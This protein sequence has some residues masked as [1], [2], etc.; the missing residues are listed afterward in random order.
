M[1]YHVVRIRTNSWHRLRDLQRVYDLDVF[2]QTARQLADHLF[3]I[4]GLLS[5]EEIEQL[6]NEGYQIEATAN[7]EK[8]ARERTNEISRPPS[9]SRSKPD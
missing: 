3:E 2:R 6:S 8:I 4:Q 9:P 5:D 7:A 1:D